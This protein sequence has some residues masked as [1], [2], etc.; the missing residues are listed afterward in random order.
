MADDEKVAALLSKTAELRQRVL[1][2][3]TRSARD[4]EKLIR[5]LA[6]NAYI[7]Q[8]IMQVRHLL[9]GMADRTTRVNFLLYV[10]DLE[11]TL[12]EVEQQINLLQPDTG[13]A[14]PREASHAV[15]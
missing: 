15:G 6:R 3:Q 5:L 12:G 11:R 10:E 7:R 2:G 8:R 1:I 14:L 13:E 9:P 4:P